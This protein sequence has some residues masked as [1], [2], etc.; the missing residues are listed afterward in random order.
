[1]RRTGTST[2]ETVAHVRQVLGRGDPVGPDE[3]TDAAQDAEGRRVLAQ[4]LRAERETDERRSPRWG[5]RGV[6]VLATMLTVGTVGA[7]ADAGGFIPT[8]V[9]KA[10]QGAQDENSDWGKL[11]TARARKLIDARSP[12]GDLVELWTA[13]STKGAECAY[14]RRIEDGGRTEDGS[15]E[16]SDAVTPAGSAR[17]GTWPG[18]SRLSARYGP[19]VKDDMGVLGWA[20]EPATAIR[21]TLQDGRQHLVPV[22]TGGF[23][24]AFLDHKRGPGPRWTEPPEDPHEGFEH[25]DLAAVDA[26]GRVLSTLRA[27]ESAM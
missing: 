2:D 23:F 27:H 15:I 12:R 17:Q 10:F 25:A 21:V 26:K 3:H 20:A 13:P 14:L 6:I 1:M 24:M 22:R 7:M 5:R 4:I 19:L 9:I 18:N 8:G 16:C 11:D